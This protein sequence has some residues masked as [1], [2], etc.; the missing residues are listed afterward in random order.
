MHYCLV[1]HPLA[2]LID[3]NANRAREGLRVLEDLARFVLHDQSLAAA[4]K[5]LRHTL[6][7]TVEHLPLDRAHLLAWR[8]TASD[9]GAHTTT[10]A[11]A[12]RTDLPHIAA[13]AG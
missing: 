7:E 13:A 6:S 5:S 1:M 10:A 3:A 11:E 2:R 8:D 12:A 9:V 4:C